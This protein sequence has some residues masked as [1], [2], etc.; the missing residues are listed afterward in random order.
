MTKGRRD[1]DTRRTLPRPKPY[2]VIKTAPQDTQVTQTESPGEI[3]TAVTVAAAIQSLTQHSHRLLAPS[4]LR[5][6]PAA[7]VSCCCCSSPVP[8]PILTSPAPAPAAAVG[9]HSSTQHS[10]RLLAAAPELRPAPGGVVIAAIVP[11][12]VVWNQLGR[13]RLQSAD[14]LLKLRGESGQQGRVCEVC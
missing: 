11:Q 10:H 9:A 3:E 8:G 6:A 14:E 4:K 5:S 2:S 12:L 1:M 7:A 13:L